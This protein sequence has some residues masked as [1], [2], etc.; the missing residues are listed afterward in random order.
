MQAV[1]LKFKPRPGIL[2]LLLLLLTAGAAAQVD[3]EEA[4]TPHTPFELPFEAID[5]VFDEQRGMLYATSKQNKLVYFVNLET[6]LVEKQFSFEWMPEHMTLT[7]DGSRLFVALLTREHSH[8]WR[9]EDGHEGYIASFDLESQVKD[10]QFWISEDPFGLVAKSNGHLVVSSGSGGNTYIRV[11]NGETGALL[12]SSGEP[13]NRTRISLHPGEMIVYGA[14]NY[15]W[16]TDIER[17]DV[18]EAGAITFRRDSYYHNEH[19]MDGDVWV[20]PLGNVL[21]TRGGDVFTAGDDV[22]YDMFYLQGLTPGTID[23]L[24]YDVARNV[25]LTAH[26]TVIAYYNL[27]SLHWSVE[28]SVVHDIDFLGVYGL[29]TYTVSVQTGLSYLEVSAHLIPDGG[30]NTTPVAAF[31]ISPP[32]D[33]TT[34]TDIEFDASASTDAESELVY[35][36]DLDDDGTWDTGFLT[37]PIFNYR[38]GTAGA[39]S[40]RL[41]VKD[42]MGAVDDIAITLSVTFEPDPGSPVEVHPSFLL[43]FAATDALFDPD[44]PF[45]YVSSKER[46]VVYFVNLETGFVEKQF[47]F[48]QMPEHMAMT[49][50][51]SRLFVALLT[52]EH[53]NE[54]S[55]E[56]YIAS[57]DLQR[58]VK[59]RQFWIAEDPFGLIAK[60]NGHLVV[61]S[62]SGNDGYIRVFDGETGELLSSSSY[63]NYVEKGTR[64]LPHPNE[65]S[66]YTA[67]TDDPTEIRRYDIDEA[68]IISYLWN[69]SRDHRISGNAW[70]SPQG[71]TMITRGGDLLTAGGDTYNTDMTYLRELAP[72][73]IEALVYDTYRNVIFTARDGELRYY[74]L[75]SIEEIGNASMPSNIS[76]FGLHGLDLFAL[77]IE[78]GETVITRLDHPHPNGNIDAPPVAHL[79]ISPETE[80]TTLTDITLDASRSNDVE[81]ALLYRWDLDSD[82]IWD[83]EFLPIPNLVHRFITAGIKLIKLQVKDTAGWVSEATFRVDVVFASDPGGEP[84]QPNPSFVLQFPVADTVF[85]PNRPYA[86]VSSKERKRVYFVNLE[87]GFVE[88]QFDFDWMPE[89]MAITPDG[90]RLFVA[91]LTREHSSYW[92]DENGH[93]GYIA[94]FDLERQV[95]DRQFW[96]SEDPFGLVAKSN[97]HLVVSSGSG[98]RTYV[99]VFDGETGALLDSSNRHRQRT[100]L[101]LHPGETIIYAADTDVTHSDIERYDVD[102][103]GIIT[104]RWDSIY[105]GEHPMSGNVWSSPLGDKVI[106]RGGGVFTAGGDTR[107]TDMIYSRGLTSSYIEAVVYDTLHN[108]MFTGHDN[109]L[110]Y[111]DLHSLDLIGDTPITGNI[112][113]LGVDDLH[114]YALMAASNQA[115]IVKIDHPVPDGD[116]NP[117]NF[118]T[119]D[120]MSYSNQD[121]PETGLQIQ[122]GGATYSMDGNRWRQTSTLRLD[123]TPETVLEFDFKS[124]AQGEVHAIGFDDDNAHRN[125]PTRRYF[126]FWGTQNWSSRAIPIEQYATPGS[127]QSYRIPVGEYFTG[128]SMQLVLISDNDVTNPVNTSWFRNIRIYESSG[129]CAVSEDF[130]GGMEGWSNSGESSCTTGAFVLGAPTQQRTGKGLV[131]PV[132]GDHSI[133]AGRNALFTATNSNLRTN[134][135]DGGTCI[136]ESPT[137]QVNETSELSLWYFH[138]QRDAN[139]DPSGDDFFALEVSTDAGA[140]YR[141]LV[142]IGDVRTAATWTNATARIGVGT[143][144][145]LRVRVSDGPGGA[146]AGDIIEAGLD[147]VMLCPV[148]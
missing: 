81:G 145:K 92:Y 15:V 34:L 98:Q 26:D 91:L 62:G 42:S 85:D 75:Y 43:P 76:F 109:K 123:V 132:G 31:E 133:R 94:S 7:P 56:G 90:S 77:Q 66:V 120:M 89:N 12:G 4:P 143:D 41:Q 104:Y 147:D 17:Y 63:T 65:I 67:N 20:S 68:G 148:N 52:R 59:D 83:T 9:D 50:D 72:S 74:N 40:I 82:G 144:V 71:D 51:G 95:K 135:V 78:D 121:R 55:H 21:I 14:D 146:G 138:G 100:R 70:L 142:S 37:D 97:G 25:I 6:G 118:L 128:T 84:E 49:P 57:F 3:V 111:Y 106:T 61:S 103:T 140:S 38:F 8:D 11:F 54:E 93:E 126:Q 28:Q 102:E 110:R 125:N 10:R 16:P 124:D 39:R 69:S 22:R 130:E 139:D 33:L 19:R 108:V 45:L 30:T 1:A 127:Y 27:A 88:K 2:L 35:R 32:S 122:D 114:V 23:A 73:D 86:Y 119:A 48:N 134:D 44:R 113:K 137:W 53:G 107:Y 46:K 115:R 129:D 5:V 131:T 105:H 24:A 79:D 112:R 101:S 116:T 80:Y 29:N 136:L 13:Y 60:S 99:R 58:Q 18:D 141:P 87:T 96:I 117:I 47:S 64:L 36:W